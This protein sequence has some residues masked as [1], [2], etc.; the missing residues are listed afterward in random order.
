MDTAVQQLQSAVDALREV[1]ESELKGKDDSCWDAT[2]NLQEI[3]CSD[4]PELLEDVAEDLLET[5]LSCC[6]EIFWQHIDG[7]SSQQWEAGLNSFEKLLREHERL[8]RHLALGEA[9][10]ARLISAQR[11]AFRVAFTS[12][13][14]LQ[15][16]DNLQVY[17]QQTWNQ[18]FRHQGET[19]ETEWWCVGLENPVQRVLALLEPWENQAQRNSSSVSVVRLTAASTD[20]DVV[21]GLADDADGDE[22]DEDELD[23]DE[24]NADNNL[25]GLR[26][27][28]KAMHSLGLQAPWMDLAKRFF[29]ARVAQLLEER[30]RSEYDKKGLLDRLTRLFYGSMLRWLRAVFGLPLWAPSTLKEDAGQT[31][32]DVQA[33]ESWWHVARGAVLR[34]FE[35]FLEVRLGEA[36]DMVRDFPESAPALLDLRRCLARTGRSSP[37]VVALRE[38]IGDRLLI[39]GAHTRDVIEVY[40][41]T[42]KAL[43]L[44]DPRG[45][46]LEGVST[47]IR[48]YLKKRKDTVRCIITALTEDS[49]LQQELQLGAEA[50]ATASKKAKLQAGQ[51]ALPH[52]PPDLAGEDFEASDDEEDP[53]AWVPDPIDADPQPLRPRKADV[54]SLL[55]GIYGSKEMFIKE[56]KEMLADRLLGNPTYNTE[57]ETQNL[58][59]LKT[60]FGDA[61]LTHCEVMLQDIKDSKRIN[62]NVQQKERDSQQSSGV[63]LGQMHPLVLSQHYWPSALSKVDHPR[64][65][66]PAPLE[67][68][69]ADYSAAYGKTKANRAVQWKRSHG[70]VEITVQFADRSLNVTVTPVHYAVLACFSEAKG[71]PTRLSL[72]ELMTQLELPDALVRKRVAFWVAKGVLKEVTANSAPAED[73]SIQSGHMDEDTE[74]SPGQPTGPRRSAQREAS[75]LRACEPFIQGMLKNYAELP[76]PRIHNFLQRFM[77]EPAYTLSEKQLRDFLAQLVEEGKLDFDGSGYTLVQNGPD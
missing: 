48:E 56:Y 27:V 31:S 55:V 15:V 18:C 61:A 29:T 74:N 12:T 33:E 14:P 50:L 22:E 41:K 30:C 63:G 49:D 66:L 9:S 1:F 23:I 32:E 11:V 39:A 16:A 6:C 52:E 57:R 17:F 10:K 53:D 54:V 46:L 60:R 38:Q 76:L 72:E 68:A 20:E 64:F 21:M 58:E 69:L 2:V 43:R 37:L 75:E 59:L 34:F 70:L 40:I 51:P 26:V 25:P 42:I 71:S 13:W 44:V 7:A 65:R 19:L 62:S 5:S 36:F 47:P 73:R 45:L 67:N 77:M 4:D 35:A 24:E 8:L 3:E 28:S